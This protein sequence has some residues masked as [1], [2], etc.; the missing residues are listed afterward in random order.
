MATTETQAEPSVPIQTV[1][2]VGYNQPVS[3]PYELP[4]ITICIGDKKYGIP[5]S[6]VRNHSQLHN[7]IR[8]SKIKLSD[9]PEDIGHT[10]VHFLYSGTY[11]TL[12]LPLSEDTSYVA[13]EHLRS[14]LVY[15]ASRQYNLTDLG[16]MARKYMKHYGEA[17]SVVEILRSTS[18][19][20]SKLPDDEN[21]LSEYVKEALQRSFM[22]AKSPFNVRDILGL[23]GDDLCFHT[24]VMRFVVEIL[25]SH[26]QD[27]EG[28]QGHLG[29][30]RPFRGPGHVI[31]EK[32]MNTYDVGMFTGELISVQGPN[33]V[34]KWQSDEPAAEE[35]PAAP[36]EDSLTV[37]EGHATFDDPPACIPAE[38]P[39]PLDKGS[40]SVEDLLPNVS[41]YQE[42]KSLST[43]HRRRRTKVLERR[44]LPVPDQDGVFQPAP[45]TPTEDP[46]PLD[47]G[48]TAVDDL[49]PNVSLYEEW[50]SLST[51]HRRRRTKVLERRG[52]PVPDQDGV[53][54][55]AASTTTEDPVPL[56]EGSTAI[57]D[58]LP[59]V[60]LY[61]EWNDLS[62]KH[63][64]RRTKVLERRGLPVPDQNGIFQPC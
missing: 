45:S 50:K 40:T 59:D 48:S 31:A 24:A 43:K 26:V 62:K 56:D 1:S 12:N 57:D 61:E 55:P 27:L 16:I 2:K 53:F 13:R 6:H 3:S 17:M 63:R 44:G 20:F 4:K 46:V 7:H 42:W 29:Y 9:V 32:R 22:S 36:A 5:E 60:S 34:E 64:R 25:S 51:K 28:H 19:V 33:F 58:L 8:H 15:R 14:V 52:L 38:D 23:C 35:P 49:L 37:G 21:W 11:E 47:E 54:Q 10:L 39:T 41:L 30:M 18:K